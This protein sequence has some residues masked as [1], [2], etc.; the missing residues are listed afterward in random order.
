[1]Q[2]QPG[3]LLSELLNAPIRP[4]RVV[5]IGLRPARRA[6][7][8]SVE[9]ATASAA[10]G[11]VGDRYNG[12]SGSRQITLIQREHLAAIA[13]HLGLERIDPDQLRRN[14]VVERINLAAL[15]DHRFRLGTAILAWTGECH[16]CSRMEEAFGPGGYNAVRGHGGIT[17]RVIE[18]G[19]I[20]LGDKLERLPAT[21]L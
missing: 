2:P 20:A 7:M 1:M 3:S 9:T 12:R 14:I 21:S 4:G 10:E 16:P 18:S 11:L 13:S 8:T 6:A 5:W 15:K 17:A 19:T